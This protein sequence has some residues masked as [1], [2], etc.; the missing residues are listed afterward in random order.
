MDQQ[1]GINENTFKNLGD[2]SVEKRKLAGQE[3]KAS[4]EKLLA[5]K[6]MD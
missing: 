4:I 1:I 2:K 5:D 3:L 6:Q